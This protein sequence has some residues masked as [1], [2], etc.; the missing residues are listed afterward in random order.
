MKT[1][2][3]ILLIGSLLIGPMAALGSPELNASEDAFLFSLPPS[4][5]DLVSLK[6]RKAPD[7]KESVELIAEDRPDTLTPEIF[8]S[9]L[10]VDALE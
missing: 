7:V 1:S 4:G 9:S 6:A 2:F 10:I 5:N 3:F 8:P